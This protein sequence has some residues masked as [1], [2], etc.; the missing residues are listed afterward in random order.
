VFDS[1][2]RPGEEWYLDSEHI[3]CVRLGWVRLGL[4]LL[5]ENGYL[6]QFWS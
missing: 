6:G 5:G 3:G 2:K 4:G 1:S